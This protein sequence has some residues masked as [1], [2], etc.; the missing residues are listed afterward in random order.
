MIVRPEVTEY[1]PFYAGYIAHVPEGDVLT[2]LEDQR[3]SLLNLMT[4]LND[5]QATYRYA[6][7]KWSIKEV[8]GHLIDAERV[9][10]YRAMRIARG[11]VTPLPGFEQNDYVAATNFD[12]RSLQGLAEEYRAQRYANIALFRSFTQV[13]AMRVGTA[14]GAAVSVRHH[15]H[16]RRA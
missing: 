11:D 12:Q 2:L 14:S 7:G 8:I 6:E 16:H 10:A 1:A 5:E 9:F 4:T 15:L 13:E 3:Q